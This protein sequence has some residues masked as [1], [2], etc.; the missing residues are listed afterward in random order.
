MGQTTLK[1]RIVPTLAHTD[2]DD[3]GPISV[4]T[5]AHV[6]ILREALG[7]GLADAKQIVD[8]C[9]F[10]GEEVEI[11]CPSSDVAKSLAD[12]LQRANAHVTVETQVVIN[13]AIN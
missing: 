6:K 1:L 7:L 11:A 2:S 5:V 3:F 8:R 10:A 4:G 9:V 12:K 13:T